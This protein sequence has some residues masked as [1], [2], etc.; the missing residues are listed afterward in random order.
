[1]HFPD[2]QSKY[3]VA[4]D[5]SLYGVA[6]VLFQ[7]DT[8]GRIKHISFVSKS[9]S[10]SQRNWST[11][12]RELYGVVYSLQKF[13]KFLWGVKFQ[14]YTDH[15]ALV[16]IHTQKLAN[17]MMIG[18][19]ETLLDF[20]FDVVHIPGIANILP[21]QLSRL[22]P[23]MDITL[24]EDE[25]KNLIKKKNKE[26]AWKRK[27]N[28]SSNQLK[29]VF[30]VLLDNV[31]KQTLDYMTP[32]E[33]ERVSILKDAHEFGHFGSEALVKEIHSNGLHWKN[34][35]KEAAEIVKACPECQ[36]HNI[37][38]RGFHPMRPIMAFL[39][40]D[41][42]GFDLAGPLPVTNETHN[43]YLMV[44]VDICT[45]YVI[46]RALPNKQSDTVAQTLINIFGD[47]GF[48]RIMQSDNGTEFKNSLM[49]EI[50]K[51]LGIDRRYSTPYHSQGNGA[52][53]SEVKTALNTLRKMGKS[54]THDW[55]RFLPMVQLAIN[56][57]IRN[58]TN[59]APF[60]LMHARKLN[61]HSKHSSEKED[62]SGM[63]DALS[64]PEL[65][66]RI[67]KM[68][69]IVFPAIKA[70]TNK[71][72]ELQSSKY[73]EKNMIIDIDEGTP[74]MV[75]LPYRSNKLA[76]IYEGPFTVVRKTQGGTY[77][78]KDETNELL[79]REYV[80]SELKVVSIDEK[81]I[82]DEIYEVEAIR[83]HRGD[84]GHRE[85]LVKW[86]GYGERANT[87]E[88]PSSFNN[89][90]T[91]AQYWDKVKANKKKENERRAAMVKTSIQQNKQPNQKDVR[92]NKNRLTEDVNR[93]RAVKTMASAENPFLRRSKR[94]KK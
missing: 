81:A 10:P 13:R 50:S 17:S 29:N 79:H 39:P 71:I 54:D 31:D 24:E 33:D 66:A 12:K 92:N 20:N 38:K 65:E 45:K 46:L 28:K 37:S 47:Y 82:E 42:I 76:P 64:L 67:E 77:V 73:D 80:P 57:K 4:T 62:A 83:D 2:L 25:N 86:A 32:P 87:W 85:Y 40:F 70:R 59:S 18:W 51:N 60:S 68:N 1:L 75:K 8:W 88:P 19:L 26:T 22:Y 55:D 89:P 53:E 78:L 63:L 11:T 74:V 94:H 34:L 49:H 72:L 30:A 43:V 93:N 41:H 16:Y 6:G 3:Y 27:N 84:V 48:P 36:K 52:S 56:Y 14:L 35:Y 69:T 9:L 90:I 58:R 61:L 91:I 7:K 44:V 23:P 21:D 5:A 15:K